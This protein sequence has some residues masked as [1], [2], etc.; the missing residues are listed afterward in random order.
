MCRRGDIYIARLDKDAEG[1]LQSGN[2][3]VLVVSNDMANEHSPVITVIP[4]TSQMGKKK[5]PTHVHIKDCGLPKP[6]IILGEQILSINQSRLCHKM[7]SI[8]K[9]VYE[10]RV[11]RAM[12][13]QLSL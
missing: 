1:S 12:A 13:I 11:E 9:T 10:K 5:L 8:K 6:S 3:P 7:G 2:R 4:I